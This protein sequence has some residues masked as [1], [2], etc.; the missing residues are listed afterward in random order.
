MKERPIIM[1]PE[2]AQKVHDGVKTQTRRIVKPQ[3]LHISWFEHQHGWCARV[4]EDTGSAAHPAYVM[5]PCPYGQVGDRLWIITL[6]PINFGAGK[7]AAGDDGN[8]YD[9]SKARPVRRKVFVTKK[10]YEEVSLRSSGKRWRTDRLDA[11]P[12]NIEQW[13]SRT[14][15]EL[16]EIRVERLHDI[17]PSDALAEGIFCP[18]IGYAQHGERAPVLLYGCLWES[19]NGKDSW[20]Q[21]PWVWVLSFRQVEP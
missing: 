11:P 20:A 6:K 21:N 5:M 7:Y 16:T 10:D 1:T 8:I 13:N 15:V 4:R 14:A 9:V 12:R 17:S 2:D 3:P 18:E 19:I